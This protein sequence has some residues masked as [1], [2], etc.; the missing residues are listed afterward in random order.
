MTN[1]LPCIVR[2]A[3]LPAS[4][5][6]PFHSH[7][8]ARV[9]DLDDSEVQLE[10]AR[11]HAVGVLHE[12]VPSATPE[13]RRLLLHWKRAC[14]NRREIGNTWTPSQEATLPRGVCA[15]M[16]RVALLEVAF[17]EKSRELSRAFEEQ[18]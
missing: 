18:R 10:S 4:A 9:L 16:K 13:M 7:L 2:V 6:E 5:V 12:A 1:W 11:A 15:A 3:G 17:E 14:F 8:I